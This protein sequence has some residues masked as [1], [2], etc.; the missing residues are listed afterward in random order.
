MNLAAK[1]TLTLS[2]YYLTNWLGRASRNRNELFYVE[3]DVKP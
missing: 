2:Q 1:L 3:W